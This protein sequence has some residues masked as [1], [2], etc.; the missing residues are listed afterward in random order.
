MLGGISDNGA[1][2]VVRGLLNLQLFPPHFL[3]VILTVLLGDEV[4]VQGIR[5]RCAQTGAVVC[6][7][8]RG[9]QQ[10]APAW[11]VCSCLRAP[12]SPSACSSSEHEHQVQAGACEVPAA[13]QESQPCLGTQTYRQ[14]APPPLQLSASRTTTQVPSFPQ[15]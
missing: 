15:L 14:L 3:A 9:E 6:D 8:E 13:S 10:P 11:K 7:R 1:A 2:W 4:S 12:L 5:G